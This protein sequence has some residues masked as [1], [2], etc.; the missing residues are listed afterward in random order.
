[1]RGGSASGQLSGVQ[2]VGAGPAVPSLKK[3][4]FALY[5]RYIR[6]L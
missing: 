6:G 4:I 3:Q 2:D 5:I 1:M